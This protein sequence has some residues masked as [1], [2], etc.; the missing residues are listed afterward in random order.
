MS[1]TPTTKSLDTLENILKDVTSV[2]KSK[3]R[4]KKPRN[5]EPQAQVEAR[6]EARMD[7]K[8]VVAKEIY[9]D[10]ARKY[11]IPVEV[12][13]KEYT[14]VEQSL[15]TNEALLIAYSGHVGNSLAGSIEEDYPSVYSVGYVAYLIYKGWL[16]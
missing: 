9:V 5:I 14:E 15:F 1:D 7:T 12:L 11:G 4:T 16:K 13:E 8:P 6:V 10:A 2:T 3:S